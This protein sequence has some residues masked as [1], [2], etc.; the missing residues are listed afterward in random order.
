MSLSI[1]WQPFA[2][3][4]LT[5]LNPLEL[6]SR[7]RVSDQPIAPL[8]DFSAPVININDVNKQK[9]SMGVLLHTLDDKLQQLN[10]INGTNKDT[11]P[12]L[13]SVRAT[14]N[15]LK[16][17]YGE[18]VAD[19]AIGLL[20]QEI[21]KNGASEE[22]LSNAFGK[23]I[24]N[25]TNDESLLN[26]N[27]VLT[28]R[29]TGE[30]VKDEEGQWAGRGLLTLWNAGM[31]AVRDVNG[32]YKNGEGEYWGGEQADVMRFQANRGIAFALAQFFD[33]NTEEQ[34]GNSVIRSTKVFAEDGHGMQG[35]KVMRR[36]VQ[37]TESLNPE[38]KEKIKIDSD[39]YRNIYNAIKTD[40]LKQEIERVVTFLKEEIGDE[41][42]A[43]MM[44]NDE[45]AF[46]DT[47][48]QALDRV[49]T[50]KGD[51]AARKAMN[52]FNHA[53]ID[54]INE[55]TEYDAVITETYY[56]FLFTGFTDRMT[57]KV[58]GEHSDKDVLSHFYASWESKLTEESNAEKNYIGMGVNQ[59]YFSRDLDAPL[60]DDGVLLVLGGEA[61]ETLING[62]EELGSDDESGSGDAFISDDP[63]A[64]KADGSA[65]N[66]MMSPYFNNLQK[67]APAILSLAV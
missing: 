35:T 51:E 61:T 64:E 3:S 2:A 65:A 54:K 47:A 33:S 26:A 66:K 19:M 21:E 59:Y 18:P 67:Q 49:K 62:L 30:E 6:M 25:I 28:L 17:I 58:I 4:R 34:S 50:N 37:W 13:N 55:V 22:A 31:N 5:N 56:S 27:K 23:L 43:N 8:E 9:T 52:F 57:D 12:L 36:S 40:D 20:R 48:L 15:E 29:I 39:V 24:N 7:V 46:M 38:M 14:I 63:F 53:F 60:V 10:R 41:Q 16:S 44:L 1:N 11:Q 42:A 32:N 45:L